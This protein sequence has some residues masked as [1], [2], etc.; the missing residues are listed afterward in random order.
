MAQKTTVNYVNFFT[1]GSEAVK[2]DPQPIIKREVTLPKPRRKKKLV[3]R[4]DPMVVLGVSVAAVLMVVML[5]GL[6]NLINAHR[7]TVQMQ[8]YVENLQQE[9]AALEQQYREAYDPEEI[10]EIA[11]A[12][13]MIPIEQAPK[14]Y[15]T[16]PAQTVQEPTAW[17]RFTAMLADIFA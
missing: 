12:M 17:E 16:V 14:V 11:A 4:S 2:F 3:I 8:Q 10:R 7:Q 1:A 13:G 9:N 6:G 5:V 15:I